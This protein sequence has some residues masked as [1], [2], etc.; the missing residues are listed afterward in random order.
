MI[1]EA[2]RYLVSLG[3]PHIHQQEDLTYSDEKLTVIA[4]PEKPTVLVNTLQGLVDLVKTAKIDH[5]DGGTVAVHIVS[6]TQVDVIDTDADPYGRRH[7]FVRATVPAEGKFAFGQF[8][9]PERFI[10]GLNAN[11][12][13]VAVDGQDNDWAYVLKVAS[14]I[15]HEESLS[16]ADDGVSQTAAMKQGVVLRT[17][18][19]LKSRVNLAPYRTFVEFDQPVSMFLL[20]AAKNARDEITLAL[21]EADGGRWKLKAADA[22]KEW[23]SKQLDLTIVR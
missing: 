23:L 17:T 15:A 18:E 8:L 10:I 9:D 2:L 1:E 22:I 16:L 14:N 21:F 7:V 3:K 13:Y 12:Q 4:P 5:I 6:P 20:R 11:F 19:T